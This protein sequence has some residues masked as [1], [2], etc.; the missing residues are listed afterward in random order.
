V[1]RENLLVFLAISAVI[2]TDHHA[3][4]MEI[5][6]ASEEQEVRN[7]ESDAL[8]QRGGTSLCQIAHSPAQTNSN[9][10]TIITVVRYEPIPASSAR[11]TRVG[12]VE[13]M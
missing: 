10:A 3:A 6:P 4:I 13:C 9:A 12:A 11:A 7:L 5:G 1:N 2:E 8:W